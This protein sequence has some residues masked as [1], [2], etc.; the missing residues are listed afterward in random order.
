[1]DVHFVLGL[2][3][4]PVL[5]DNV[6][7]AISVLH[8]HTLRVDT[9]SRLILNNSQ[10]VQF[11]V[12]PKPAPIKIDETRE[13][14]LTKLKEFVQRPEYKSNFVSR[15]KEVDGVVMEIVFAFPSNNKLAELV[16]G[17]QSGPRGKHLTYYEVQV[18]VHDEP[19]VLKQFQVLSKK[20]WKMRL[21]NNSPKSKKRK[22]VSNP[23]LS[24]DSQPP[25]VTLPPPKLSTS[26]PPVRPVLPYILPPFRNQE[27]SLPL[28]ITLQSSFRSS[29]INSFPTSPPEVSILRRRSPPPP[30]RVYLPHMESPSLDPLKLYTNNLV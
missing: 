17:L 6:N 27:T 23:N 18:L 30:I 22:V 25:P 2:Q 1:M 29:S 4:Y 26:P 8:P 12:E 15:M 14:H 9:D 20:R 13:L 5:P 10:D 11:R 21:T 7:I 28:V 16:W 19:I 3:G 24:I